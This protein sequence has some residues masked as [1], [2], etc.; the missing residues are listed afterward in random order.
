MGRR[1]RLAASLAAGLLVLAATAHAEIYRWTDE[2]GQTHFT[3]DLS[4]VPARYRAQ[5]AQ[6][7]ESKSTFNDHETP[8][9]PARATPPARA[10]APA[11][12]A[13]PRPVPRIRTDAPEPSRPRMAEF[14][15]K[16]A[17]PRRESPQKYVRDCDGP[18]RCKSWVNPEWKQWNE[19]R[20]AAEATA[21]AEE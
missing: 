16:P 3:G 20:K 8:T 19:E 12:D 7:I 18:G 6:P 17:E 1:I 21:D 10:I 11:A 4:Q 13:T 15:E 5:A 14:E 2:S 9:G